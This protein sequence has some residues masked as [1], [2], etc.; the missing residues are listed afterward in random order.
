VV[1]DPEATLTAEDLIAHCAQHLA[2]YKKPKHVVFVDHLPRTAS[3]KMQKFKL[4]EQYAH[5]GVV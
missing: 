1:R 5:L 2:G 4:R 3:H